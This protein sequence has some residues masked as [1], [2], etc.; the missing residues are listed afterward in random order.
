MHF[1]APRSMPK[2]AT[3]AATAAS[4]AQPRITRRTE[5]PEGTRSPSITPIHSPELS[6]CTSRWW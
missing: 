3:I 2:T 5:S 6:C 4:E 1:T